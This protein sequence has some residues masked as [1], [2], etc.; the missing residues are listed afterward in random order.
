MS[1]S[2]IWLGTWNN[3]PENWKELI[4]TCG[5]IDYACQ[6]EKAGTTGKEHVQF[7]IKFKEAKYLATM[8]KLFDGAHL[9]P[10]KNWIAAKQYCMKED[11]RI[12]AG[13]I[14]SPPRFKCKDPLCGKELRPMQEEIINIC[15]SPRED[16][17]IHWFYDPVGNAGKTTLAKHLILHN[18]KII[19]LV[20]KSADMKYGVMEWLE[21]NE[22]E[23]VLIDLT[24]SVEAFVSYQGIEEIKN[25]IFYNTKYECRM[26][27]YDNPHVIILANFLPEME[28]LS[29][30][31]WVIHQVSEESDDNEKTFPLECICTEFPVKSASK[32]E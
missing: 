16:R 6:L 10:A 3:F 4:P 9:E 30:D 21:K 17:L 24:R 13:P 15:K 20:G 18:D 7:A 31:R 32:H 22:L 14:C 23:V 28:K 2:R 12:E 19:Y 8:K 27:L 26:V 29:A 1:R 25:G 5:C 11:T